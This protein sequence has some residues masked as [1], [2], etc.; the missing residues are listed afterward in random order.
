MLTAGRPIA[1]M[2]NDEPVGDHPGD[3]LTSREVETLRCL[4]IQPRPSDDQAPA[5]VSGCY[6]PCKHIPEANEPRHLG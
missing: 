2:Q 5:R 4:K 3:G 1:A 6:L